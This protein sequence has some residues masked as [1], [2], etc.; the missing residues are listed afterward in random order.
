M[1]TPQ[2]RRTFLHQRRATINQ[3]GVQLHHRRTGINFGLRILRGQDSADTDDRHGVAQF[4]FQGANYRVGCRKYGAAGES[5][6]FF[7]ML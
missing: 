1:R 6:G 4:C 5:P 3:P 7:G 2:R